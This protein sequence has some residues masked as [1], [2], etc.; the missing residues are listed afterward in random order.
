[1]YTVY[2]LPNIILPFFGGLL[3]D[4]FGFKLMTMVFS[5]FMTLGQGILYYGATVN[6]LNLMIAGRLFFGLGGECINIVLTAV[7]FLWFEDSEITFAQ[8]LKFSFARLSSIVNYNLSPIF[9]GYRKSVIDPL[10]MGFLFSFLATVLAILLIIIIASKENDM[11][12]K[13]KDTSRGSIRD[14]VKNFAKLPGAFWVINLMSMCF[15]LNIIPFNTVAAGLFTHKWMDR[16]HHHV[17]NDMNVGRLLSIPYLVGVVLFPICGRLVDKIGSRLYFLFFAALLLLTSHSFFL[18]VYPILPLVLMGFAYSA[19]GGILGPLLTYVIHQRYFGSAYGLVT[20]FLNIGLSVSPIIIA[21]IRA[22]LI[23]FDYVQIFF[24][25]MS[26]ITILMVSFL[27]RLDERMNIQLNNVKPNKIY[28]IK[29]PAS[30]ADS[31]EVPLLTEENGKLQ[32]R[33]A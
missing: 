23:T 3:V 15:Y 18:M 6:S 11:K 27:W 25:G 10:K 14:I 24:I 5:L 31:I 22:S 29:S 9:F 30:E 1:M 19:F 26:L 2:S 28:E 4:K 13:G 21:S 33:K 17:S 8:G 7:L 12:K 16:A 32:I 20:S